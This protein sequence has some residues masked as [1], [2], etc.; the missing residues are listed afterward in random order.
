MNIFRYR[1]YRFHPT[2]SLT[3]RYY[4][5]VHNIDGFFVAKLKKLSNERRQKPSSAEE[6]NQP[7]QEKKAVKKNQSTQEMKVVKKKQLKRKRV[8][9]VSD[10]ARS[11][12]E[13]SSAPTGTV[14][15]LPK[16]ARKV[17][18]QRKDEGGKGAARRKSKT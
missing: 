16:I 18:K 5:H 3:R 1:E 17:K 11:E 14:P 12:A 4:P 13:S 9:S 6:A 10:G 2:M 15:P 8:P 7:T